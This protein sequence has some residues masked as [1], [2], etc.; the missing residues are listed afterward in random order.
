M[1]ADNISKL[2]RLGTV[3]AANFKD[4]IERMWASVRGKE[5]PAIHKAQ[6]NMRNQKRTSDYVW[7]LQ[8]I[9]FE[10]NK[11]DVVGIVGRN[12]A[13]K[14]TLL[15]I[16]SK[17]TAPTTGSISIKGRVASLLEVGTG[18]HPEL[19]GRDN[20]FL[21]GHI[22]GMNRQ[23]INRKFDE[24]VDFAGVAMYLDTPVKRYSSGMYVRLAFAVAAHLQPDI[25]IIDEVL[26]VGDSEFQKKCLGKM[27]D[28]NKKEGRTILFVSHNLGLVSRL[29]PKS[30]YMSNGEIMEIG[31]T[32][33]IIEIYQKQNQ[34]KAEAAAEMEFEVDESRTF[35][36]LKVRLR[37]EMG[38]VKNMFSCDEDIILEVDCISRKPVD[39][40]YGYFRISSADN[41]PVLVSD[42]FD[43]GNTDISSLQE[44]SFTA[45]IRVP[46][47]LIGHGEYS[48]YV[49]FSK[50][51]HQ[52]L[53][54]IVHEP[55]GEVLSLWI[56]DNTTPRG[57]NRQGFIST[58]LKWEINKK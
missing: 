12:G 21:N 57:N 25:L 43:L 2:Y 33:K 46:K 34:T 49:S 54:D 39:G 17:V 30:F 31:E 3:D 9:N 15:K 6:K 50:Q 8:N 41:I 5:D 45:Q 40:L 42:T 29:C 44:G 13:G 48:I 14:S 32:S 20:I 24:I 38:E 1:K 51:Q 10:I 35:Q 47:R 37:D 58:L 19:T 52:D 36:M 7:A 11:G 4:D 22:L 53:K 28:V 55:D 26:A 23:E 18:F 16:L 56:D 27:Q